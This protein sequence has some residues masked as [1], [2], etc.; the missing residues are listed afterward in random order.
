MQTFRNIIFLFSG[1][2]LIF[3]LNSV[4]YAKSNCQATQ[5]S[6]VTDFYGN[7]VALWISKEG[8]THHVLTSM[9]KNGESWSDPKSISG[10]FDHYPRNLKVYKNAMDGI[11]AVWIDRHPETKHNCL[12]ASIF[13]V[14]NSTLE[15]SIVSSDSDGMGLMNYSVSMDDLDNI[16]ITWGDDRKLP[17][18]AVRH[19]H[20]KFGLGSWSESEI[21]PGL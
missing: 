21:R 6:I 18:A 7:K 17:N 9:S 12:C 1:L 5:P 4:A 11:L 16:D 15:T 10:S 2:L 8:L 3:G 19:L 13:D 20:S 14:A